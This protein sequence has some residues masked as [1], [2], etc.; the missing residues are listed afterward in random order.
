MLSCHQQKCY[1]FV[2]IDEYNP[3]DILLLLFTF[4]IFNLVFSHFFVIFH[5]FFSANTHL[6]TYFRKVTTKQYYA[7]FSEFISHNTFSGSYYKIILRIFSE[8]RLNNINTSRVT[9]KQYCKT[10]L[11]Y[12][13]LSNETDIFRELL[14]ITTDFFR[15]PD[16]TSFS[17]RCELILNLY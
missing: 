3:F 15:I 17:L 16:N 11:F 12:K 10:I 8:F 13:F 6:R 5:I 4:L 7:H 2:N 1:I 9:S 14:P